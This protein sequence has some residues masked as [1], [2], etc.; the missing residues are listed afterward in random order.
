MPLLCEYD[1]ASVSCLI[2]RRASRSVYFSF[3]TMRSNSSP[4][5]MSSMTSMYLSASSKNSYSLTKESWSDRRFIA[6]TSIV[7][8]AL[9]SAV[10]FDFSM[11]LTAARGAWWVEGDVQI[12]SERVMPG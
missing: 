9:S 4:P 7:S 10:S 1:M 12:E 11:S 6:S 8:A 5:E 3:S 2:T